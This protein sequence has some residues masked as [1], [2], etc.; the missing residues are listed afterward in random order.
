MSTTECANVSEVVLRKKSTAATRRDVKDLSVITEERLSMLLREENKLSES[1]KKD[2]SLTILPILS[3]KSDSTINSKIPIVKPTAVKGILKAGKGRTDGQLIGSGRSG[4][5]LTVNSDNST[6]CRDSVDKLSIGKLPSSDITELND[7]YKQQSGLANLEKSIM[8]AD[9]A[10]RQAM[11]VKED[12]QKSNLHYVDIDISDTTTAT[13]KHNPTSNLDKESQRTNTPQVNANKGWSG[14]SDVNR[15][16]YKH[17]SRDSCTSQYDSVNSNHQLTPPNHHHHQQQHHQQQYGSGY[18][19]HQQLLAAHNV[20]T[21]SAPPEY[22]SHCSPASTPEHK[23]STPSPGPYIWTS[24]ALPLQSP[25]ESPRHRPSQSVSPI[26]PASGHHQT[27]VYVP[28]VTNVC[29]CCGGGGEHVGPGGKR[30]PLRD[31]VLHRRRST[32]DDDQMSM[33]S[34]IDSEIARYLTDHKSDTG[35]NYDVLE[36]SHNLSLTREVKIQKALL[37]MY[38]LSDR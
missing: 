7:D 23:T 29:S 13:G 3:V 35:S 20:M 27:I 18:K 37:V 22:F 17:Q 34:S 6:V 12:F 19:N 30:D 2:N 4:G 16:S 28:I 24:H 32:R 33:A 14:Y 5:S 21:Q 9:L 8:E 26:S 15:N 10:V 11:N 38:F 1:I 31:I 25:T 36:S